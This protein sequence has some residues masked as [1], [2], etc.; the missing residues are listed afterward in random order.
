MIAQHILDPTDFSEDADDA[1][2]YAIEIVTLHGG[3]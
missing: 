2:D 1:L 3:E